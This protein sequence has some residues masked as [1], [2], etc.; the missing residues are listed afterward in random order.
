[1]TIF[2]GYVAR[3]AGHDGTYDAPDVRDDSPLMRQIA[4]EVRADQAARRDAVADFTAACERTVRG[5]QCTGCETPAPELIPWS[6][7]RLCWDCVDTQLDLLAK[8]ILEDSHAS[9]QVRFEAGDPDGS[10]RAFA[11]SVIA[12]MK[13]EGTWNA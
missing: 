1:M 12:E 11:D 13:A 4:A 7:E 10:V 3:S 5:G 6:G 9:L 8:A 2:S